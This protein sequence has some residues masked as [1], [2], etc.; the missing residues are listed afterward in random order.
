MSR[1]W[2]WQSESGALPSPGSP[3]TG[4]RPLR[5]SSLEGPRQAAFAGGFPRLPRL[6]NSRRTP[7]PGAVGAATGRRVLTG[8]WRLEGRDTQLRLVDDAVRDAQAAAHAEMQ[9]ARAHG[10]VQEPAANSDV[11]WSRGDLP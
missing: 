4:V 10:N 8:N 11:R 6:R 1:Q 2:S 3:P 5:Q 7:A 9:P